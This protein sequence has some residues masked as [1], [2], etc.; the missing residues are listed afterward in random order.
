MADAAS[1]SL[2]KMPGGDRCEHRQYGYV[3]ADRHLA[4][5]RRAMG[6]PGSPGEHA[7]QERFGTQARAAAFYQNQMLDHLNAEMC[8]F[9]ARQEMVFRSE[10]HTSELQSR[11]HLVCRLLLEN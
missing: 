11:G 7:L 9:I 8:A 1:R 6:V 5:R 10:E 2:A 4:T 3:P